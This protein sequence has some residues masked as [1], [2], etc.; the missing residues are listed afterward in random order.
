[1]QT[2]NRSAEKR[3]DKNRNRPGIRPVFYIRILH[4]TVCM[5]NESN[6]FCLCA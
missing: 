4:L 1:M 3:Y 2:Q 5:K 6:F